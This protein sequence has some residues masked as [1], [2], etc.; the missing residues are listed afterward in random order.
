MM[1]MWC[2]HDDGVSD[3]CND[4]DDALGSNSGRMLGEIL[5]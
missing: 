4:V 5:W 3:G 1:L 2:Q